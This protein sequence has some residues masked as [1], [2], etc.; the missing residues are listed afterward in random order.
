MLLFA[1]L[2][3]QLGRK[4]HLPHLGLAQA[5][6]SHH[7]KELF[8]PLAH[9]LQTVWNRRDCLL[10]LFETQVVG[11]FVSPGKTA[12]CYFCFIQFVSSV[13]SHSPW[14]G[15]EDLSPHLS[16]R[17]ASDMLFSTNGK[18]CTIAVCVLP[19]FQQK[20]A[21]I[22]SSIRALP[23]QERL[24]TGIEQMLGAAFKFYSLFLLWVA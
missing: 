24:E 3:P 10:L 13:N 20:Q 16:H 4:V 9:L 11:I 1:F 12:G 15:G 19:S 5:S 23:L 18:V 14:G 21:V 22:E 2:L 6:L 17:L 8:L 7:S